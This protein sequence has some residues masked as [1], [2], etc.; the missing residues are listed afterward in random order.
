M[1][2]EGSSEVSEAMFP[3]N[4]RSAANDKSALN[5]RLRPHE[6]QGKLASTRSSSGVELCRAEAAISR[7]SSPLEKFQV[8]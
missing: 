1:H 4:D 7:A 3:P 6:L 8:S 5:E 2:A